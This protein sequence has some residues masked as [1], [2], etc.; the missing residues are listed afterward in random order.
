MNA[1][2]LY[3]LAEDLTK[4]QV[5]AS[6]DESE[7]GKVRPGQVVSFTVDAYPT[8]NFHGTVAQVRLM[9]QTVQNVVTYT[10]VIDVPNPQLKLKPGMTATVNIEIARREDVLRAPAA[11]L[12]FRPT[13]DTFLALKQEVPPEMQRGRGGRGGEGR[14]TGSPGTGAPASGAPASGGSGS[15]G[16]AS[17]QQPASQQAAGNTQGQRRD[18]S[19]QGGGDRGGERPRGEGGGRGNMTDEERAA[20]RKQ[21]EEKLKAMSPE[22]RA[23]WEQRTREGRG[24]R[25]AGPGG[26]QRGEQTQR[27]PGGRQGQTPAPGSESGSIITRS[28]AQTIDALFA[29]PPPTQSRG[30]LWLYINKQ[31]K[32]VPVR[33]GI[34]DGT[35]TEIL[36]T[37]ETAQLAPNTEVVINVVTGLEPS[38]LSGPET[39]ARAVR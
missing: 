23:Q 33:T 10:T 4:M 25:G 14:G 8:D 37:P 24:S 13:N 31:L 27:T 9:P 16:A 34:T 12:R 22:E 26:V 21:M 11:A 6:I 15:A 18:P 38:H 7:I 30:T 2:V 19:A 39:R 20:R 3:Q 32:S 36:E 1:P 35:W 28:N 5:L 17:P 29:A